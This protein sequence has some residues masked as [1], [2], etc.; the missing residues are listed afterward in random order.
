[1]S[2]VY[3]IFYHI[4]HGMKTTLEKKEKKMPW[5]AYVA[6]VIVAVGVMM[7]TMMFPIWHWF[8]VLVTEEVTVIA[9]SGAECIAE[10]SMG[11]PVVVEQCSASPGEVVSASFYVPAIEQSGHYERVQEKVAMLES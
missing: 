5:S 6:V 10:S 9:V 3:L 1:M 7:I 4:V 11:Y 2:S 8:P